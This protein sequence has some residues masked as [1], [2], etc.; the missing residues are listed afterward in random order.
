MYYNKTKKQNHLKR[1]KHFTNYHVQRRNCETCYK[2]TKQQ[3]I[4][5][6][7]KE[8]KTNKKLVYM[9]TSNCD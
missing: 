8:L 1:L 3:T 7:M 4:I 5:T 9:K 2:K 6:K